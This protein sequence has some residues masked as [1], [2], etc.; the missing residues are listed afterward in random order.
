[1]NSG[2]VDLMR[3]KQTKHT[4][5]MKKRLGVLVPLTARDAEMMDRIKEGEVFITTPTTQRSNRQNGMYWA[6][7]TNIVVAT[8]RWPTPDHLHDLLLR[9]CGY[10]E[11]RQDFNGKFYVATDSTRFSEMKPHDFNRYMDVALEKLRNILGFDPL[12]ALPE[13]DVA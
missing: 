6:M 2:K 13:R 11:L 4:L 9:S 12:E 10:I 3:K 8:Q 5:M 7:L 1:M